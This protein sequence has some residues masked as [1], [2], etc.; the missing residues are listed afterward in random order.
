MDY[1][2]G[3]METLQLA[4]EQK[5]TE[6]QRLNNQLNKALEVNLPHTIIFIYSFSKSLDNQT[7]S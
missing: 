3:E 4:N 7:N 2:L 1:T 5:V 6:I